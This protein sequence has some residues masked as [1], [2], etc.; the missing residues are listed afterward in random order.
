MGGA[1]RDFFLSFWFEQLSREWTRLCGPR[2]EVKGLHSPDVAVIYHPGPHV[3]TV[4]D[5]PNAEAFYVKWTADPLPSYEI[6]A[7]FR[8]ILHA[9]FARRGVQFI[10]GAAVATPENGVLL[11]GKGG[12]GKSTTALLCARAGMSYLGDDYCL[13]DPGQNRAYS[14]YATAKLKGPADVER[15]PELRD[16]SFNADGFEKGGEGKALYSLA[17]LWPDRLAASAPVKAI[18]IPRVGTGPDT[19]LE[20]CGPQEALL[21]MLP[22]TV[23]Q[24]PLADAGDCARLTQ[25][26]AKL[27]AYVLHIG[28]DLQQIPARVREVCG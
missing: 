6:G 8:Y 13:V 14:I 2:G 23:G 7:P 15:V 27:P 26:A 1:P 10:H 28:T 19:R 21:A 5:K 11:V 3:L 25:L 20:P 22:S 18:L 4:V 12:S 17:G 24:L 16:L 9:W